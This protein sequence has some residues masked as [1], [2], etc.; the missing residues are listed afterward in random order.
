VSLYDDDMCQD[1]CEPDGRC[2]CDDE[3]ECPSCGT[4]G[5]PGYCDDYT[6]YNLRPDETGGEPDPDE[7][8][9][10]R[11]KDDLAQ[12]LI[13]PDGTQ[14]EPD[15]PEEYEADPRTEDGGPDDPWA[16]AAEIPVSEEGPPF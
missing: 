4:P 2:T 7:D 10:Q 13:N 12:G 16:H 6:T 5:C 3:Y 1:C 14:R 8:G 9:H 11:Y 15:P